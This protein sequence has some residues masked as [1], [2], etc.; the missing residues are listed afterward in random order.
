MHTLLAQ[1]AHPTDLS[2]NGMEGQNGKGSTVTISESPQS[3][4]SLKSIEK[5]LQ[6]GAFIGAFIEAF[7][8]RNR[9]PASILIVSKLV[10]SYGPS[11]WS[12]TSLILLPK[13]I[14]FIYVAKNR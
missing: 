13:R 9:T 5:T 6:I 8:K 14:L 3:L 4:L 12:R 7:T 2:L 1:N 10:S 11:D